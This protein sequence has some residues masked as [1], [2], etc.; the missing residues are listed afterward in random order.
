MY[1]IGCQYEL[2]GLEAGPCPE[3]GLVFD[4]SDPSSYSLVAG[5]MPN[6]DR[7]R[8]IER[9]LI[10]SGAVPVIANVFG[11]V[12]LLI[13][14]VSL[15]RWPYRGGRDD[16]SDVPGVGLTGLIAILLAIMI[17]PALLAVIVFALSLVSH[18]ALERAARGAVLALVLWIVGYVL[19][20]TDPAEVWSWLWD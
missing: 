5:Y 1:C 11:Y 15:G 8:W 14:R 16:P 6:E 3:C 17:F 7:V 13:A 19:I 18:R 20:R 12:S 4:P 2:R 9:L 10:A